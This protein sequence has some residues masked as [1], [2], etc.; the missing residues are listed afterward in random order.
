MQ[1]GGRSLSRGFTRPPGPSALVQSA[2][3]DGRGPFRGADGG[4]GP[5]SRPAARSCEQSGDT[6]RRCYGIVV[7]GLPPASYM[8]R[9]GLLSALNTSAARVLPVAP[10]RAR[11]GDPASVISSPIR[12]PFSS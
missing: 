9:D 11:P 4:A 7:I 10:S 5:R 3:A 2:S 6:S 12:G 1:C 8:L